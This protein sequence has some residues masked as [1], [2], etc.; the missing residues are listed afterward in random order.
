MNDLL[1]RDDFITY[2]F[3]PTLHYAQGFKYGFE[4]IAKRQAALHVMVSPFKKFDHKIKEGQNKDTSINMMY[5]QLCIHRLCR[6]YGKSRAIHVRLDAGNDSEDICK[7]RNQICADGYRKYN[8]RPNCMRS[9][10]PVKSEQLGA[11][12]LA[13]VIL[14]S[15]A[16]NRNRNR[17]EYSQSSKKLQLSDFALKASGSSNWIDDTPKSA[18]FLTLWNFKV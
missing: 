12:Q 16:A 4:L 6:F 13:D 1:Q 18:R 8:T 15:I 14:G 3:H 10:E 9:I 7:M 17:N 5:Y 2:I 11:V